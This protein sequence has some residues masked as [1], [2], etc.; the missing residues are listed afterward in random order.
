MG[1]KRVW[2]VVSLLSFF[3]FL[4]IRVR[5]QYTGG[6]C[7]P[8]TLVLHVFAKINTQHS[9]PSQE[10]VFMIYYDLLTCMYVKQKFYPGNDNTHE[11]TRWLNIHGKEISLSS[12]KSRKRKT[13]SCQS[14]PIN[15]TQVA[16]CRVFS[17]SSP[18]LGNHP[19][20]PW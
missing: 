6:F 13:S 11:P 10:S 16:T 17:V 8:F 3:T 1:G 20:V 5:L 18:S 2:R 4:A 14:L 9:Q 7:W 12:A 19:E 15:A